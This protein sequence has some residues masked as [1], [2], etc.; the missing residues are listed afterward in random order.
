V[1]P[2]RRKKIENLCR[3]AAERD[4]SERLAFLHEACAGDDV[5]RK[6]V[7]S[8]LESQD[9][10]KSLKEATALEVTAELRPKEEARSMV[11]R[12][13]GGYKIL[14]LLRAGG[15]GD[16]Y[17]ARNTK[18]GREVAIKVLLRKSS[19]DPERVRRFKL[20]AQAASALNHPNII[21]IDEIGQIYSVYYMVMEL[22]EGKT[23][24]EVLGSG[25]LSTSKMLNL[26]LQMAD[27]LAKAHAAGITHRDL[28]PDN[29]IVTKDGLVKILDFGLAT[30]SEPPMD[31]EE[32]ARAATRDRG[33]PG[34]VILGDIGYLSPEQARG[35][36]IDFQT[37]QFSL[38]AILYE[39]ATGKR[40]FKGDTAV[41][42]LSAIIQDEPRPIVELNPKAAAPVRW[43]I[44][45]CLMKD[46]EERYASTHDLAR[47]LEN[48]LQHSSEELSAAELPTV[49][50]L[51]GRELLA[52]IAAATFF[53][54]AAVAA[55][56]GYFYRAPDDH[57]IFFSVSPP[58]QEILETGGG[59]SPDGNL[60]ALVSA[61]PGGQTRL[62]IRP[63]ESLVARPLPGT[64]GVQYTFW[65]PD[66]RFIGFFAQGKL[67]KI[68]VSGGPPQILCDA[69]NGRGGT[70]NREGTILFSPRVVDAIYRVPA[71]GGEPTAVTTTETKQETHW[72]P[73]FLPDGRHFLYLIRGDPQEN[74]MIC[75]GSLDLKDR[76]RL[77]KADSGGT[78]APPG[79]LL[80]AR[81]GTLL[82][83]RFDAK[84]LQLEGD[85][86]PVVESV[87]YRLSR[88][89][90]AF[91][92]SENGRL[93]YLTGGINPKTQLVWFDRKG[94]RLGS[95]TDPG[96][97]RCP[98]LSHDQKRVL[99]ERLDPE[100]RTYD[101]WLLE[102]LRGT[103]SRLTIDPSNDSN[104][105][106][107]P[108][109]QRIIFTSN[110][111]GHWDIYRRILSG[112]GGDEIVLESS[113]GKNVD[114]WSEDGRFIVYTSS[115][116]S[117]NDLCVLPLFGDR[118]PTPFLQTPFNE[119]QARISPNGRWIAY[120][121]D[122]SGTLQVYVQS[123]PPS[124]A[125]WPISANGGGQPAWRRDGRELF[126]VA[127]DK[128]IMAA[129]VKE[130]SVFEAGVPEALFQTGIS[131]LLN[132]RNH[133]TVTADG[134]RF[135]INTPVEETTP[136]Q[137]TVV[138]NWMA[139]LRR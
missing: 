3:A 81:A 61:D 139:R 82:A 121:S 119:V 33:T 44:E 4:P 16:V 124:G 20:E 6:E 53:L 9:L 130:T 96:D 45:R 101:I 97:Y 113:D 102:L 28:K 92:I 98:E 91:S 32:L 108:D 31:K 116:P 25:P 15:M 110:R 132:A 117:Y 135:L 107:S 126:Y 115:G 89:H 63:L 58:K 64:E 5:M 125:K 23:L 72:W 48:V 24:R 85:P 118:K 29:I 68:D 30:L 8:K 123:F 62:W 128:K 59:L 69:P 93:A 94:K 73:Y 86:F 76:K 127:A 104:G 21:T 71:A 10:E 67:K 78:Y 26:A 37:D 43:I 27:G 41:E 106:W 18:L 11:G 39:M 134:R 133:Y 14:G 49:I 1:K 17:R 47:E 54:V 83:Q 77:L 112:T 87:A 84:T 13:I 131:G 120:A 42:T 100:A 114:Q 88:G 75:L 46:A 111:R 109:D 90:A 103:R 12:S 7:Q 52:W 74:Q 70:W 137:L 129:A 2:E 66:S 65:S 51:R 99:V 57:S 34:G 80:F 50:R 56:V 55:G 36:P 40:A 79:Y 136:L 38:G 19:S 105:V 22:V 138:L 122:E 60:L 35:Q 95:V